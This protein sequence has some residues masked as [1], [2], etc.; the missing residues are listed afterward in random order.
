LSRSFF[1][2]LF[3]IRILYK[4]QADPNVTFESAMLLRHF[5]MSADPNRN[6]ILRNVFA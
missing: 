2:S 6:Q 5:S 3:F 4:K 1:T